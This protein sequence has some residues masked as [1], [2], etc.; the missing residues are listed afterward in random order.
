MKSRPSNGRLALTYLPVNSL[1][2]DPR[3]PRRH[4]SQQVSQIARSIKAFG[5]AAPVLIDCNNKII[6]GTGRALAANKLGLAEVPVI[7]L[8][9]LTETQATA[10]RV[11]DNRLA[12]RSTWD[13]KLL[14]ATLKE[15]ST[16]DLNFDIEAVG[17]EMGEIDFR[18]QKFDGTNDD[19][20]DGTEVLLPTSTRPVTRSGDLWLLGDHRLYCGNALDPSAYDALMN[21]KR[22]AA[23]ISDPP[24]NVKVHGHASRLGRVHHR[25]FPMASG[26]MNCGEY[27]G[28]LLTVFALLAA[29][30]VPGSLVY[31]FID[32]RHLFEM[33]SAERQIF[34][35]LKN[36]C[37]WVKDRAGMGSFYRSQHELV[38]VFKNGTAP[39][40]N[41]MQLGKFGRDRSNVW[42]YPSAKT[43]SLQSE[44]GNLASLHPTV[45]SLRLVGDAILDCSACGE[46]ILDCF[47]GSGTTL[48]AAKRVGRV[49]YGMDLDP[50]YCDVTIRRWQ[51]DSG[52]HAVHAVSG[53]S[54]DAIV[55]EKGGAS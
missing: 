35:E 13:D 28:F 52:D 4:S 3:N 42:N 54:F 23:S 44:E 45:K 34:H 7:R 14:A 48:L 10:L 11:A 51:A 50:L 27:T 30:T 5:F 19:L 9:N 2:I 37:V 38:L 32:W 22:A 8:E 55:K 47:I 33:V 1:I 53:E 29:H 31:T 40:R 43:F 20:E 39:H 18:I 25:E 21:G 15:L 16:A 12:E 36:V 26:E 17:F 24:F 49:C 6:A 46:V 41:N